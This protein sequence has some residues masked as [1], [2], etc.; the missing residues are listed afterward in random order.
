LVVV[1]RRVRQ[2]DNHASEADESAERA[3]VVEAAEVLDALDV[4]VPYANVAASGQCEGR[5]QVPNLNTHKK[6]QIKHFVV[7]GV[8]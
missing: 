8:G 6:K 4:V 1:I 7:V 2:Q 3:H 5:Q